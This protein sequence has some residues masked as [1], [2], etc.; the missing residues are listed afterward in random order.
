[1]TAYVRERGRVYTV[2]AAGR[3]TADY[4]VRALVS[5][6]VA[7]S[8]YADTLI[9]GSDGSLWGM[10]LGYNGFGQL[11]TGATTDVLGPVEIFANGVAA[12]SG[13]LVHS[14]I[15]KTDHSLSATA[16]QRVFWRPFRSNVR[17]F[18]KTTEGR[19]S[20]PR[21]NSGFSIA[22]RKKYSGLQGAPRMD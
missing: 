11:G 18:R 9:V 15:L 22:S 8:G 20:V 2:T 19:A 4:T 17:A 16:T 3:S 7:I 14:V 12:V 6:I 21:M 5:K 13:G 1:M 10:G